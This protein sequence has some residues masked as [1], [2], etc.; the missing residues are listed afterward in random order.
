MYRLLRIPHVF[1]VFG[2][3]EVIKKRASSWKVGYILYWAKLADDN[4]TIPRLTWLK[5]CLDSMNNIIGRT[6]IRFFSFS[7]KLTLIAKSREGGVLIHSFINPN[8]WLL[9]HSTACPFHEANMF[10]LKSVILAYV[11]IVGSKSLLNAAP[12]TNALVPA[13]TRREGYT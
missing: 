10:A 12:V 8:T 11:T 4:C 1:G 9:S 7:G 2:N 5:C 13:Q 3:P 6:R